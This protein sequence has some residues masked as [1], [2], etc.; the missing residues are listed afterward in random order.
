MIREQLNRCGFGS[1]NGSETASQVEHL[2][3]LIGVRL[4]GDYR[5]FLLNVDSGDLGDALA[6]CTQPTPFGEHI[7]AELFS[8]ANVEDLLDST[9]TPRNMIC[10]GY[11]HFGRTTCLLIAGAGHGHLFSLDTETRHYKWTA[12]VL[13]S[14][15]HLAESFVSSSDFAMQMSC[16]SAP[17]GMKTS[18]TLLIRSMSSW[19]SCTSSNATDL[20]FANS[21]VPLNF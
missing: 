6:N 13:K 3:S 15:P 20:M 14:P 9:V 21:F 5:T 18:F 19:A 4:P 8:A 11:G 10:I 17:G 7:M 12:E 1:R 16:R 2:E